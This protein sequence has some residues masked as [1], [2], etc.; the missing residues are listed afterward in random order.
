MPSARTPGGIATGSCVPSMPTC[1]TTGSVALQMAGDEMRPGDPRGPDRHGL[2]PMRPREVVGG[3]VIPEVKRQNELTEIT[4]TVGSVFL[5]LTVGCARCHDHKF[6]AI[7][8]H[9]L[10]PAPVLLR[11]VRAGRP[12]DRRQGRDHGLTR[13][14]R[15]PSRRRRPRS[16][17]SSRRSRLPT[18]SSARGAEACHAHAR[19][20]RG[21]EHAREGAHR[22][23]EAAGQG[24][25]ERRCESPGKTWP[26]PSR[27]IPPITHERESLKQAIHEIERTLPRPPAH[28]MALV[29][30][31]P[32]AADTFVFRRGD[33][34][35]KGPKVGP[36]SARRDPGIAD[37]P[38]LS[39]GVDRP[40]G[41]RRAAGRPWPAGSPSPT[42]P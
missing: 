5:G 26:R 33:Y 23:A 11:G 6:D 29:D 31:K 13:P 9:R 27:R 32:K 40:G 38:S 12:A 22:R 25:A 2:R 36:A 1:P 21:H 34:R 35:N 19:R 37:R 17:S 28:A 16:R 3:N 14:R 10:L 42:I 18:A 8:T 24:P 41:A 30:Q 4:C 39:S 20:A 15:R 7:P